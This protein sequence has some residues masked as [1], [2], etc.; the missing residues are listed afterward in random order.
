MDSPAP[1]LVLQF[2]NPNCGSLL[3]NQ[4]KKN[5]D[6]VWLYLSYLGILVR[7]FN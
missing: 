3:P 5:M 7:H 6:E 1:H 2:K 4:Q